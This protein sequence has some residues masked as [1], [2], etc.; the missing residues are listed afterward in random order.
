MQKKCKIVITKNAGR[1]LSK[2][3]RTVRTKITRLIYELAVDY[4]PTNSKKLSGYENL[5]RLRYSNYRI[6]YRI[7]H[8]VLIITVVLVGHRRDVYRNL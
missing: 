2:L 7:E 8:N 6:V 3:P 4:R 1:Q 5:Y